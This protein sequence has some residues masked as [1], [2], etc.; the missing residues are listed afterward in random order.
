MLNISQNNENCCSNVPMN[1]NFDESERFLNCLDPSGQFTFQTFSD[2]AIDKNPDLVR[3][4]NGTFAEHRAELTRLNARGAGVFVTVN[5]TNGAGRKQT[6]IVGVRAV[7]VDLDGAPLGP[8][9]DFPLK[10]QIIV[11]SSAGRYHAYWLVNGLP[12]NDFETIQKAIIETFDGDKSVKD[13][14]RVMRLPGFTWHKIAQD[15]RPK[16]P[17]FVTRLIAVNEIPTYSADTIR[18]HFNALTSDNNTHSGAN[19]PN[20]ALDP[21]LAALQNKGL[22]KGPISGKT[23]A[24]DILCPWRD[25]HTTGNDGTAYFQAHYNGYAGPGFKCQHGHCSEKTIKDLQ[26]FLA[27]QY[28]DASSIPST[29]PNCSDLGNA[30]RFASRYYGTIRYITEHKQWMVWKDDRWSAVNAHEILAM[31]CQ[32]AKSIHVEAAFLDSAEQ[33]REVSRF[34][35]ASQNKG[36]LQA[37]VDLAITQPG[38]AVSQATLDANPIFLGVENGVV[39]LATGKLLPN[40]PEYLITK[41]VRAPYSDATECAIWLGFLNTIFDGDQTLIEYIQKAIGYTLTGKTDE[42]I[43]F[44]LC[45]AG[46]NGKTV[47]IETI[48]RLLG[49]HARAMS[50][51]TLMS[52]SYS[53]QS[54]D[55]ARLEGARLVT[56]SEIN[57]GKRFDEE[58]I[59]KLTGGDRVNARYLYQEDFEFTPYFKVWICTNHKPNAGDGHAMWRRI[60]LIPFNV[61]IPAEQ[62]DRTLLAKLENELPGI[63]NWAVQGCLKYQQQGLT[64]PECIKD[65]T[66]EYRREMDK[67]QQW[68]DD[69]CSMEPS[70]HERAGALYDSYKFYTV[71]NGGRPLS[72]N[73]FFNKLVERGL[74]KSRSSSGC[75]YHG[76]SLNKQ[77][78]LGDIHPGLSIDSLTT[79]LKARIGRNGAN[80]ND[81]QAV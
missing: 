10:P 66:N 9:T 72:S 42:Q 63:L 58:R 70:E 48:R 30:E 2:S 23:G 41:Y 8:V 60:R 32:V 56:V 45:G 62:Q 68:L 20:S 59:K 16:G 79:R 49:D 64:E 18:S 54:N 71:D 17:P 81:V 53:R 35:L 47:F 69:M 34:A 37:M 36:R 19:G 12:L 55:I 25:T 14:P 78:G 40:A 27:I 65:A 13:L 43:L 28:T 24:Y 51:D 77:H 57:E 29:A 15:G 26:E 50:A 76:L 7:F 33:Q 11:E 22:V 61:T 4:L 5:K 3:V 67:L 31:A 74:T 80:N 46:A 44:M 39:D 38:I 73:R 6:N 1:Q 75:I 21:I 52:T